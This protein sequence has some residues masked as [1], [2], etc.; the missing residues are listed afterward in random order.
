VAVVPLA[1]DI[2]RYVTQRATDILSRTHINPMNL[3][4]RTLGE[5]RQ[6]LRDRP[7]RADAVFYGALRDLSKRLL[8][9]EI[10][11]N[12]YEV[13]AEVQLTIQ[14][15]STGEILWSDTLEHVEEV[16]IRQTVEEKLVGLTRSN[17]R[18]WIYIGVG[19][20][21][22]ILGARFLKAATRVR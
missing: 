4:V 8:R 21:V 9:E 11:Q 5:A 14:S 6:L 15:V 7:E 17:P 2:D 12:T 18:I 1:G 3:D 10:M 13:S 20:V 22:L 19:L 16:V